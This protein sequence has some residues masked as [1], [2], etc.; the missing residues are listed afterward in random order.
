MIMVNRALWDMSQFTAVFFQLFR[1]LGHNTKLHMSN[2]MG[3]TFVYLLMNYIR[4]TCAE[5][6]LAHFNQFTFQVLH[7]QI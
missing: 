1:G 3:K 7:V 2:L 6:C 4:T 5:V